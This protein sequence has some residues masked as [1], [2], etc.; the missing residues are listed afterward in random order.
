MKKRILPALLLAVCALLT[1]TIP[2]F[3]DGTPAYPQPLSRLIDEADLLSDSEEAQLSAL[4][5]E[6][7]ARTELDVVVV[8]VNST[9]MYSPMEYADDFFDYNGYGY[10]DGRDGVLLLIAMESRDWWISTS[11]YGIRAFT[12]AGIEY[13]GE[14]ILPDLSGGWYADAF[15]TFARLC[16]EFVVQA[17]AGDPYDVHNL[18]KEPLDP[19]MIAVVSL[20]VGLIC[21]LIY[22]GKLKG[23]LKSVRRQVAARD[24]VRKGSLQMSRTQDLYLYRNVRRVARQTSSS[25][26]SST[27]TSSS[28]RS[29]GGGGGRF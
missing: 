16:E 24:Y 8:T 25:G 13:I 12:D 27:H 6:V 14:Q 1:C 5:D 28:G 17:R 26:G 18:P 2:V 10:G 11:G 29:H 21:A 15:T 9:G 19:G 7:R 20:A 3:A 23:D 4:L 22:T